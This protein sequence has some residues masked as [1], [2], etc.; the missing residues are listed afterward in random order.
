MIYKIADV[1]KHQGTIDWSQ[2][3]PNVDGA[4]VRI[5]YRGYLSTGRLA[6]DICTDANIN[7]CIANNIP[8]G[9]YFFTQALTYTEGANEAKKTLEWLREYSQ[10]PLLPVFIDSEWANQQHSGRAD[11][12][13]KGE[14]TEAVLGF[15]ET[16]EK[17]G[18]F[19]GIY[20]STSWFNARLEDAKLRKYAH[21]VADY[22]GYNGYSGATLLWQYTSNG[23]LPGI[24]GPVDLSKTELDLPKIIKENGLN[25]YEATAPE[26]PQEPDPLSYISEEP[27]MLSIGFASSGDIKAIMRA[28]ADAGVAYSGPEIGGG[29]IIAGPADKAQQ[30][31]IKSLCNCL[32]VPCEKYI[33]PERPEYKEPETAPE[34]EPAQPEENEPIKEDEKTE[35]PENEPNSGDEDLLRI[36]VKKSWLVR[37]FEAIL[38]FLRGDTK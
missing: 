10:Q 4:I 37:L 12:L 8:Y 31:I 38:T 36:T 5:G 11:G 28:A 18:Y 1:S 23:S 29:Y 27:V 13:T 24:S 34:I 22:R 19:A 17:A 9:V 20:A 21:W 26:E 25:G 6:K 32:E 2:V 14:R 30:V 3:K 16:I 7:G 33:E 35:E 15:L